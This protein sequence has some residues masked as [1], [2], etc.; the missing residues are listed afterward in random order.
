MRPDSRPNGTPR[1]TRPVSRRRRRWRRASGP[2]RWIGRIDT[3]LYLRVN[4]LRRRHGLDHLMVAASR[5]MDH[6]E[7]WVAVILLLAIVSPGEG[8]GAL[9]TVLPAL[10]LTMLTINYPVKQI[11]RRHRP[12]ITHEDARVIGRR[13]SDSSFPSGHSAAAFAG[14]ILVVPFLPAFAI[15]LFGYATLVAFSRVYLGVHYPSDVVIGSALGG[16]L[17]ALYGGLVAMLLTV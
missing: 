7:G 8:F 1:A 9:V 15:A 3:M 16:Y 10:W 4:R 2:L 6:G 5:P 13:P 11:F 12:F 17:A 14:A